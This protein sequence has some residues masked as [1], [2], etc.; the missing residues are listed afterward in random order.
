MAG[1]A[2]NYCNAWKWPNMAGMAGNCWK[3]LKQQKNYWNDWKWLEW[4]EMAGN[5]ST[6]C[7]WL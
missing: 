4:L 5:G 6:D 2:G 1:N 7:K 3:V